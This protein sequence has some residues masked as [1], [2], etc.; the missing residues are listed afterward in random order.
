MNNIPGENLPLRPAKGHGRQEVWTTKGAVRVFHSSTARQT[1]ACAEAAYASVSLRRLERLK[2]TLRQHLRKYKRPDDQVEAWRQ[3][4]EIVTPTCQSV[5]HHCQCLKL[6]LCS[7]SRGAFGDKQV[8]P[9]W[10]PS[11]PCLRPSRRKPCWNWNCLQCWMLFLRHPRAERHRVEARWDGRQ[12]VLTWSALCRRRRPAPL[13]RPRNQSP[14][15]EPP[16]FGSWGWTHCWPVWERF[17][18]SSASAVF[19]SDRFPD[20][21]AL[22]RLLKDCLILAKRSL[23]CRADNAPPDTELICMMFYGYRTCRNGVRA[24]RTLE[25]PFTHQA[26]YRIGTTATLA[27]IFGISGQRWLSDAI[28]VKSCRSLIDSGPERPE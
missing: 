27:G 7:Q 12:D 19:A 22:P 9:A 23:P 6:N 17:F 26:K 1:S 25:V 10:R 16:S 24:N 20:S 3:G 18:W 14:C 5:R 28:F 4:F 8:S 15:S 13:L 2:A 11:H 21:N